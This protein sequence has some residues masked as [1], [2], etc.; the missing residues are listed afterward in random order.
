VTHPQVMIGC[1]PITYAKDY[2]LLDT[3]PGS[4]AFAISNED[5][6]NMVFDN[7]VLLTTIAASAGNYTRR[8]LY[9]PADNGT[10]VIEG[11]GYINGIGCGLYGETT[12]PPGWM[13]YGEYPGNTKTYRWNA[14][15][16]NTEFV[17]HSSA[18][19][20]DVW[21]DAQQAMF[22]THY[23]GANTRLAKFHTFNWVA[24]TV[25]VDIATY[26]AAGGT[27]HEI[28]ANGGIIAGRVYY[29]IDRTSSAGLFGYVNATTGAHTTVK[30]YA[31]AFGRGIICAQS[32]LGASPVI[33]IQNGD[34]GEANKI[35]FWDSAGSRV[36]QVT[37]TGESTTAYNS[38]NEMCHDRV[39]NFLWAKVGTSIYVID[40]DGYTIFDKFI[41]AELPVSPYI[42]GPV[43]SPG[44]GIY[45]IGGAGNNELYRLGAS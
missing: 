11:S 13:L 29:S 31:N 12:T 38:I 16:L 15:N 28:I 14:D 23:D 17:S 5:R 24:N 9:S 6:S 2:I 10:P 21:S 43:G 7:G 4:D 42:I 27:V 32:Y 33:A 26:A 22:G 8:N 3:L 34:T 1:V 30:D 25:S 35:D 39:N 41:S 20:M 18:R 45:A 44:G 36:G 37:L 40:M 19:T